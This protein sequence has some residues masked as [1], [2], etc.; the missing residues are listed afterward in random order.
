M[1][2]YKLEWL[3]NDAVMLLL[4]SRRTGKTTMLKRMLRVKS[5]VFDTAIGFKPTE[6]MDP[7]FAGVFPKINIYPSNVVLPKLRAIMQ[8]QDQFARE[9][10]R[11]GVDRR[12]RIVVATDDC[13]GEP[14]FLKSDELRL[15][16]M[17]G[18]HY[19]FFFVNCAQYLMDYPANLRAQVEI[20]ISFWIKEEKG[21]RNLYEQFFSDIG[22]WEQFEHLFRHA[23]ARGSCI[24]LDSARRVDATRLEDYVFY[25]ARESPE[26]YRAQ[27]PVPLGRKIFRAISD[28]FY[29]ENLSREGEVDVAAIAAATSDPVGEE[30]TRAA[31]AA[32]RKREALPTIVLGPAVGASAA[33]ASV[34]GAAAADSA[35]AD[36]G[37]SAKR[38]LLAK[39]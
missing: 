15:I 35:S 27:K 5:K 13:M 20:V 38:M 22:T 3:P 2:E 24:V 39:H 17:N 7:T 14:K 16:H 19:K 12:R 30:T 9:M 31:R 21:R 10:Q 6:N 36:G 1:N 26:A 23:T 4:G 18:R 28:Y 32:K 8:L 37:F 33:A 29:S 34:A 25:I 11:T